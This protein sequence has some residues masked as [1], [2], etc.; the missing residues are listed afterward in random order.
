MKKNSLQSYKVHYRLKTELKTTN[1]IPISPLRMSSLV[2]V[3][4]I[5]VSF[6]KKF[7]TQRPQKLKMAALVVA[8]IEVE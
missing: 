6:L 1:Q 5:E 7:L 8:E 3:H 2:V 4:C